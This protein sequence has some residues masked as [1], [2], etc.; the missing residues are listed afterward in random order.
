MAREYDFVQRNSKLTG[1][2]FLEMCMFGNLQN[3]PASLNDFSAYL[4]EEHQVEISKQG[5]NERF[6]NQSV[7][8]LKALLAE[9][10]GQKLDLS[11]LNPL[12]SPF[13]RIRIKDSTKWNLPDHCSEK[14]KGYGGC[15]A[16]SASMV[17][18]QFEYDLLAGDIMDLSITSG[19]RNDQQDSK[20]IKDN[21]DANDLLIRDLAYATIGYMIN[22]VDNEAYFLNRMSPQFAAY[23]TQDQNPLDLMAIKRQLEKNNLAFIEQDVLIGSK[24]Y[25]PC[26]MIV[27]RVP[28]EVYNQRIQKAERTAKSKGYQVTDHYKAR[29]ALSIFLTNAPLDL[30]NA[31]NIIEIY[32]IRWQVELMFKVWKS[33]AKVNTFWVMKIERFESQLIAKLIWLMINWKIFFAIN[34][35]VHNLDIEHMCS[36]WKFYKQIIRMSPELKNI[37]WGDGDFQL[38]LTKLFSMAHRNLLIEKKKN[39]KPFYEQFNQ[40]LTLA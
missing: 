18:V 36:I 10:M 15:R 17:S 25:L 34:H 35:W 22:V 3:T 14:Y 5:I 9:E 7:D 4:M 20:E 26:R 1:N 13:S 39:K 19:T 2:H 28:Q 31:E 38:W 8:F 27:T 21:I 33:L 32:R 23:E 29:A 37:L 11:S 6:N 24:E 16:N 12:S 40:L 30:L